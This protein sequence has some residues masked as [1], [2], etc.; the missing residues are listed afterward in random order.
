MRKLERHNEY[1]NVF[2][3][4]FDIIKIDQKKNQADS[5]LIVICG[6]I[7]HSNNDLSVQLV[8]LLKDFFIYTK[9]PKRNYP[10]PPPPAIPSFLYI[11]TNSAP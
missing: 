5:T 3:K 4:L 7:L 1:R 11:S 8:E 2:K 6:D 9:L 10:P